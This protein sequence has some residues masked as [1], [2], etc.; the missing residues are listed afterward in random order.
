MVSVAAPWDLPLSTTEVVA[1]MAPKAD[2]MF[3][4]IGDRLREAWPSALCATA[5]FWD[6]EVT[7]PI[8]VY[9]QTENG[10]VRDPWQ[11]E[12]EEKG[13]D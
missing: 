10:W 4:L 12:R 1:A 6:T 11:P 2:E 13:D 5:E 8:G 9:R 3:K 7:S